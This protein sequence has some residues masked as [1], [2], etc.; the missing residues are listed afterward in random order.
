ME[1]GGEPR[2]AAHWVLAV[3]SALWSTYFDDAGQV[4]A[5]TNGHRTAATPAGLGDPSASPS[6]AAGTSCRLWSRRRSG[7]KPGPRD[8]A[9]RAALYFL[10]DVASPLAA[11]GVMSPAPARAA[12]RACPARHQLP[13]WAPWSAWLRSVPPSLEAH[14]QTARDYWARARRSVNLLPRPTASVG[15]TK[16][17]RPPPRVLR[18]PGSR[19]G[20]REGGLAAALMAAISSSCLTWPGKSLCYQLRVDGRRPAD[21][22]GS[23]LAWRRTNRP[24]GL[25]FGERRLSTCA[26]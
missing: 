16:D 5:A 10:A 9:L 3:A 17:P 20:Q 13:A 26:R 6:A 18:L 8:G 12:P 23:R 14:L 25:R 24:G 1:P 11:W 21:R 2:L 7:L 4:E 19:A 15:R 22:Q